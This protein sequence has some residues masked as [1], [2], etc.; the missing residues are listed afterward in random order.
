MLVRNDSDC[1]DSD[2][3]SMSISVDWHNRG[4][5]IQNLPVRYFQTHFS[6]KMWFFHHLLRPTLISNAS[7]KQ[8]FPDLM[9]KL[10]N[11]WQCCSVGKFRWMV[12]F[13]L[14]FAVLFIKLGSLI[15]LSIKY[16]N[17]KILH[18]WESSHL[19]SLGCIRI[20]VLHMLFFKKMRRVDLIGLIL[21]Y[22]CLTTNWNKC[23]N[24]A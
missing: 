10:S 12:Y 8:Y 17:I 21:K 13:I 23:G 18:L 3:L 6:P 9:P 2:R 14:F 19:L 1:N 15:F 5:D 4:C 16:K 11:Y 7:A 24:T 20:T 22:L